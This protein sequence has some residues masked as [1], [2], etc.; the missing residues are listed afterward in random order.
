MCIVKRPKGNPW[1]EKSHINQAGCKVCFSDRPLDQSS[2]T[3]PRSLL[4]V[5]RPAFDFSLRSTEPLD[6]RVFLRG[7]GGGSAALATSAASRSRASLA[8]ALLR[9]EAVGLDD[10]DAVL[11]GALAGERDRPVAHPFR[12]AARVCGVEAQLN[13]GRDLVDVLPARPGGTDESSR[14]GHP[15]EWPLRR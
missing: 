4:T 9:A 3:L 2:L 15:G 1:S 14:Q 8:V 11:G 12:Q 5:E 6:G 7:G 10:D 13:G